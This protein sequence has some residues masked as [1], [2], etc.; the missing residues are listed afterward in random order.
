VDEIIN[1]AIFTHQ[2]VIEMFSLVLKIYCMMQETKKV[3]K[4]KLKEKN[5]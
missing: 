3:T 5:C 1:H 2:L 4:K